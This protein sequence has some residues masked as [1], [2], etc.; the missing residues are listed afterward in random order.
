MLKFFRFN[1]SKDFKAL[2]IYNMIA[3]LAD[4]MVGLFL[5]IF[6]FEKFGNSIHW[7]IIF[8]VIGHGLYG[9]LA[10]IGAMWMSKIG[11]KKSIIIARFFIIPFYLCLYFFSNNPLIFAILANIVL[12]AFR[13][14]YWVPYHV[15]FVKF[16]DGK[17]RG[18]QMAYLTVLGYLISIGAPLMAGV[19]LSQSSF[20]ILFMIAMVILTIA[21]IPLFKISETKARFEYSY[22][23]SW[24][25]LFKKSR[26]HTMV[27]YMADGAQD[28]V[29]IVIWPIFIYQILEKQYLAVG[30]ITA[31][32]IIGTVVLQ[33]FVG[34]YT[35]KF[36]KRKM[37]KTGSIL[38]ALGWFLKAFAGTTFQIF[39]VG[40]FH[41]FTS[42][43]FRTPFDALYYERSADHGSYIDEYTV[44]K[45]MSLGIGRILMGI[46]LIFLVSTVSLKFAFPIAALISLFVNLL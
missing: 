13:L 32:I 35:D 39:V 23:G 8:Y 3:S 42:I 46:I 20:E 29:G 17:S 15:D 7:V 12:L 6:L 34:E 45:E 43:I 30:A 5:P 21:I 10:P 16:T 22:F 14:F 28:L 27:A 19:L 24:K 4:G 36:P 41:N 9:I 18:K 33:I 40:A 37:V 26:R 1:F 2:C 38:Y 31:L 44:L 25:E 11:L